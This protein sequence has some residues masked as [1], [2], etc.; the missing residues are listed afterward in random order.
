MGL[1][2]ITAPAAE[3]V[4][5]AECRTHLGINDA[6]DTVQDT[7]ITRL[8]TVAREYCENYTSQAFITQTWE[9]ALNDFP[10]FFRLKRL[11]VQSVSSIKYYDQNDTEQTVSSALYEVDDYNAWHDIHLVDGESWPSSNGNLN[12]VKVRFVCGHG[13]ATTDVPEQIRM[14]IMLCVGHWIH[15]KP[16]AE[17]GVQVSMVPLAVH[18]LLDPF[19]TYWI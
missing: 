4:T 17:Q 11:P 1:K 15:Y 16:L 13:D 10:T 5:L 19:K 12:N 3:P 14:A 6:S 8:I 9:L 18:R 7:E 2:L